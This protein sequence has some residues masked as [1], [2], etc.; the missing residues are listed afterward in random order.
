MFG[1]Q[2]QYSKSTLTK[3]LL[4]I[5][6]QHSR[7]SFG[8]SISIF[9]FKIQKLVI[10]IGT[11]LQNLQ[12]CLAIFNTKIK[13]THTPNSTSIS[14]ILSISTSKSTN[15]NQSCPALAP[16]AIYCVLIIAKLSIFTA[17][18]HTFHYPGTCN[19]TQGFKNLRLTI[20]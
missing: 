17:K 5:K 16:N 6:T 18:T 7:L 14:R 2:Y 15:I 3:Q 11:Q 4:K 12:V 13:I 1:C 9:K 10:K 20:G 8:L 19:P